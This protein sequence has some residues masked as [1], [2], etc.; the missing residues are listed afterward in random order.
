MK[1][2]AVGKALLEIRLLCDF[3][4]PDVAANAGVGSNYL[5]MVERGLRDPSLAL[6]KRLSY[7]YQIPL[8]AIFKLAEEQK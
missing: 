2:D 7:L 8:S 5:G 1:E 3:K 6:L 4:R